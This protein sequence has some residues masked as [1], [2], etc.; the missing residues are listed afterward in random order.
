MLGDFENGDWS[1]IDDAILQG[2]LYERYLGHIH[3]EDI[4]AIA[5]PGLVLRA[6][7][8]E[9]ILQVLAKACNLP[10]KDL[11]AART[12]YDRLAEEVALVRQGNTPDTL[13]LR[14]ELRQIVLQ[15]LVVN[16]K[17]LE[18]QGK[19]REAAITFFAANS[20]DRAEEILPPVVARPG[21]GSD[22]GP[23]NRGSRCKAAS[24]PRGAPAQARLG[25]PGQPPR[26]HRRRGRDGHGSAGRMGALG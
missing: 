2:R 4:R 26:R 3:D 20:G 7:T 12:L 22:R 17:T 14:P 25:V 9:L 21:H 16:G 19:I 1:R 5:H 24:G 10:I 6:I 15:D 13:E 11:D 8:P 18:K 23:L